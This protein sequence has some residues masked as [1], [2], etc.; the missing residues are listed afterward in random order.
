MALRARD[1]LRSHRAIAASIRASFARRSSSGPGAGLT[2]AAVASE[3]AY[4]GSILNHAVREG[5]QVDATAPGKA[6]SQ[7]RDDGVRIVS[8]ERN[9]RITDGELKAIRKWVAA[10]ASR[11]SIPLADLI[12]FGLATGLRRGEILALQWEDL[13]GRVISIRR[14]HPTD[15]DLSKF[16]ARKRSIRELRA[17][18][19]AA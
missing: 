2:S 14:K 7:L 18:K 6:R 10:N 9:R 17:A 11:T 1:A 16:A 3:L 15:A 4:V 12:E 5:H 13:T 19:V 8:K